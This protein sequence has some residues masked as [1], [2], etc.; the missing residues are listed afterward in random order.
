MGRKV[1]KVG[2]RLAVGSEFF[3]RIRQDGSY[4]VDKTEL[5]Y[6]L[7]HEAGNMVT[8]FTRPRRF[9]KTLTMSMIQNFFD[10]RRDSK[11]LFE[12]LAI[13]RHEEFC[14]EWMNQ[15]PV[16]FITLKD[17]EGLTFQSAYGMLKT[18]IADVCRRHAYLGNSEKVNPLDAEE[19]MRLQGNRASDQEVRNSVRLLTRM[20]AAHY[21]K[22]VILLI[23]EYDVPLAKASEEKEAG[24]RY[25]P[26]MLEVIRGILSLVLKSN[27]DLKFGVV[28]GCLHI[29]KESIFT[30]VNN[31]KSYSV[32]DRGFSTYFGFTDAE[33]STLLERVGLQD[34]MDLVR[35]WYDGYVM[36]DTKMFCPWDVINYVADAR[37][38]PDIMPKNYWK[39]TS[40]NGVVRDFVEKR[41]FSVKRQF[42]TLMNGG[43][44]TRTISDGLTYDSLHE[45]EDNLWSVLLMT[46]YLTKANP[47]ERGSTV[48]LRIPNAEIASIFQDTV[49]RYFSDHVDGTRQRSMMD[50]LWSG[51]E[52]AAS[53]L[54]SD[55]LWQTISYMDYHE[56]YYHAFLAGIFVGRGY[57]VESNKEHGLGRPD[58]L[59][60]DDDNRRALIIEAKKSDGADRME[61]DCDEA[62]RQIVEQRYAKG[63][64]AYQVIC[65]GIAFY[66]K[67]ALVRRL[68]AADR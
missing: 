28:T 30:G 35:S 23:D 31:F 55:F 20:M 22:P 2:V 49:A 64:E 18:S 11:R 42:E 16:L 50:A 63:L 27:E 33:V 6:E 44:I 67:T 24:E 17:V 43:T 21:G 15:Y 13:A 14:A 40:G 29:A 4:Y 62:L 3:D 38:E 54:I 61:H 1:P 41:E 10:V 65:Y 5:I 48:A 53:K 46:G 51:D 58:I 12:G 7:V 25:Y 36:G 19:F 37:S 57:A 52:V 39:N 47:D 26:Q 60:L 45:A 68:R 66:Q 8:L 56:D 32:L 59:L 9:G 34:R